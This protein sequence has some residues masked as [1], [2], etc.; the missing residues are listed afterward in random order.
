[1][2]DERYIKIAVGRDYDDVAPVRGTYH[3]SGHCKMSVT[4][5]VEKVE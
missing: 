2:A 5:E 4:V 1:L 3:G